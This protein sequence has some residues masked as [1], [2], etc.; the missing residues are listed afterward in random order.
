MQQI[1]HSRSTAPLP[2]SP[3]EDAIQRAQD[4]LLSLQ[5]PDGHWCAE[6]EGDT[7]LESEY[8]LTLHYMGRSGE[9]RAAKAAQYLRRRQS[10][11]G[12]WGSYPGGPAEVSASVKAY[13]VLK[14]IGDDPQ[15]PHMVKARETILAL[16]GLDACNSFTKLYLAIFGQY[17]W[18]DAPAVPPEMILLPRWC[19]FNLYAM[20]AWT[21]T[22][23][24]PLS[25]IWAHRPHCPLPEH[26][27]IPELLTRPG[28]RRPIPEPEKKKP[29]AWRVVFTAL[30]RAIKTAERLHL[31]APFRKRALRKA[32]GWVLARLEKGDGLGAI[33][34]PIINTLV[35]FHC[36]G[37]GWDH[38]V[39]Q[40][41]AHEL[42]KLEIEEGD[43]LRLQP[44][45]SPVWDTALVLGA[46]QDSGFAGDDPALLAGAR[47]IL[48]R[49]VT[50]PGDWRVANPDGPI[51]GWYFE[52][53]NDFYPDCD[54]TAEVL[55]ALAGIHFPDPGEERRHRA[56]LERGR[57]WQL[58]M[59]N[60]DGG[61]AAFDKGCDREI[62]TYIPFAD[63][64]AMIDPST[65]DITART[66]EGLLAA[67]LT[68]DHP[69]IRRGV[70]FLEKDQQ[71]DGSWYGR[72]GVNYLYGTWLALC[73]LRAAG[74]NLSQ[75][76]YRRTVEWLKGCQNEDG[77]W[78]E[79][80]R[81]YDDP[82]TRGQ[83][84]STAAQTAWA[85]LG[86]FA[87]GEIASD[88]V[89]R[90]IDFLLDEQRPDGTWID[91]PWTGTG[92][93]GVFYLRYHLYAT[94]FP[95]TALASYARHQERTRGV[96]VA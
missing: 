33:F 43:S 65:A 50:Q 71:P 62:L 39:M 9:P 22:I 79:S 64:N 96:T 81:S 27:E 54:D 2:Q 16:G 40:A 78:G 26:A 28:G 91:A 37:Y 69:A 41:Q 59:Q 38:P 34:P 58:S 35:G 29:R 47:W 49:E 21:R 3:T 53:A 68:A 72:W 32:E 13:L 67:G 87:A 90:G 80:P 25:I 51:G 30:D 74:E 8:V 15:A 31:F 93:P 14:L 7:I 42:E 66:L 88:A 84:A 6:L 73:G 75:P 10:L 12:G 52:Y 4:A 94:Y 18:E 56:A 83:G 44:C 23:V 77:G 86:L 5:A 19:Y 1:P 70:A 63:H 61:W 57:E 17:R 60:Q 11:D 20:S 55:A 45:C 89:Q 76:R 36:L 48:N 46:L 82:A 92:F 85:L 24:V 95:L